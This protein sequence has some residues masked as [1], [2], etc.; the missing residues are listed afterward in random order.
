M[1]RSRHAL[2]C[3]A[4]CGVP[5]EPIRRRRDAPDQERGTWSSGCNFWG[6]TGSGVIVRELPTI[7]DGKTFQGAAGV[8]LPRRRSDRRGWRAVPLR[9]RRG[10]AGRRGSECMTC[11]CQRGSRGNPVARSA[12][13]DHTG[14]SAHEGSASGP[15]SSCADSY[16]CN[17]T[18]PL[19]HRR[20]A[21]GKSMLRAPEC[22]P[23]AMACNDPWEPSD[24]S[25]PLHRLHSR[26]ASSIPPQ[27]RVVAVV[28][29][30][31]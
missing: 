10:G 20:G 24:D 11:P 17:L 27:R 8:R 2:D 3:V 6:A 28:V 5:M 22:R 16:V 19:A 1:C 25:R 18:A 21:P 15:R 31:R 23:A 26:R 13:E 7:R 14:P 4:D 30:R 12:P 9:W 29:S